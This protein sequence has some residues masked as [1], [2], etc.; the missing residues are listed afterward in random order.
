MKIIYIEPDGRKHQLEA[1]TGT[2]AMEVAVANNL[3]GLDGDCGGQCACGT[4]HVYI[5]E[6]WMEKLPPANAEETEMLCFS[7]LTQPNSR[8]S[9]QVKL[10]ESHDGLTIHLP[11]G[12]H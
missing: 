8:L 12:Q 4:C 7:S 1:E 3:P 6:A 11:S 2:S 5:D 10:D 9:C